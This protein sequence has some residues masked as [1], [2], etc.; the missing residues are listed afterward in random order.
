MVDDPR[1][2]ADPNVSAAS[3]N[4]PDADQPHLPGHVDHSD[5]PAPGV[6]ADRSS[7]ALDHAAQMVV[8]VVVAD[9]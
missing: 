7:A 4:L 8:V 6:H 1:I 3:G 5:C 2:A 9:D